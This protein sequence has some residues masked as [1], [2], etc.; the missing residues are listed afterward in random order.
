MIVFPTANIRGSRPILNYSTVRGT[1]STTTTFTYTSVTVTAKGFVVIGL[2]GRSATASSTATVTIGGVTATQLA[3]R[4]EQGITSGLYGAYVDSTSFTVVTTFNVNQTTSG[5]GVWV[6][7]NLTSPIPTNTVTNI[8]STNSLPLALGTPVSPS[9]VIIV[10]QTGK[11]GESTAMTVVGQNY[12]NNRGTFPDVNQAGGSTTTSIGA[13]S[14]QTVTITNGT[15]STD[16][17][18]GVGIVLR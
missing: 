7:R 5:I 8:L 10:H 9:S 18:E 11:G 4:S 15:S 6:V 1:N 12:T 13:P 16:Y 17:M 14:P 2:M 3:F